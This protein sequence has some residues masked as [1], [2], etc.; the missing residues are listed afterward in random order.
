[1]IDL[2]LEL[3]K[4][5]MSYGPEIPEMLQEIG[6]G[7]NGFENHGYDLDE[8][9]LREYMLQCID[10]SR[11]IGLPPGFVPQTLYWL[12]V[13]GRPVGYAKL[14][15]YL[16]ERLRSIGGH[17]GY[18]IRPTERYKGYG[19]A[20][21]HEMLIKARELNIPKALV[22]CYTDNKASRGVIESNGGE[23]ADITDGECHYWIQLDQTEGVRAAHPDDFPEMLELWKRTPGI[24]ITREDTEENMIKF[25]V[26]NKGMSFV[27]KNDNRIVGTSLCGHDGRRGYI[28]LTA[29]SPEHR[30]KGI[31][32]L[33]VEK[34]L[35]E[36]R[37]AGIGKC[38]LFVLSDNELGHAFWRKTGWVVREDIAT[39]SKEL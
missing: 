23:L 31:G 37:K 13:D 32:R 30:G 12:Y 10:M 16:N 15:E 26:R 27:C 24:G 25:L 36:L 6:P 18:C 9:E 22:T 7:E 38:R 4:C 17:I 21:L 33:L 2:Q 20:L 8:V 29:V 34:N 5:N 19:K 28:Y 39:Y 35:E 14:R 3:V 11:G 1:M